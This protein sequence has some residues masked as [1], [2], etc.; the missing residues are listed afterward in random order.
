MQALYWAR[1]QGHVTTM[2]S[3]APTQSPIGPLEAGLELGDRD[4]AILVNVKFITERPQHVRFDVFFPA[5]GKVTLVKHQ[6]PG[7]NDVGASECGRG[8]LREECLED[9]NGRLAVQPGWTCELELLA[10]GAH[11]EM[12]AASSAA[13]PSLR[14]RGLAARS[15]YWCSLVLVQPSPPLCKLMRNSI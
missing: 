15:R 3:P 12:S 11:V 1:S 13:S 4:A 7:A 8:V 14:T 6:V 10:A 9:G 5:Q 2:H